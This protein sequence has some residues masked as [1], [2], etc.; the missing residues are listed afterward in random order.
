MSEADGAKDASSTPNATHND[1]TKESRSN[2]IIYDDPPEE[3]II[4]DEADSSRPRQKN[5]TNKSSNNGRKDAPGNSQER[6]KSPA[7]VAPIPKIGKIPPVEKPSPHDPTISSAGRPF[8]PKDVMTKLVGK[9]IDEY[10][11]VVDTDED[12][13]VLGRVEGDLPSMVGRTV[14]NERGDVHDEDGELL[15]YVAEVE[16]YKAGAGKDASETESMD[17]FMGRQKGAFRVDGDGNILDD[18]GNIV[19]SFHD[20]LRMP[21]KEKKDEPGKNS[22]SGDGQNKPSGS[23]PSGQQR[24]NAQ[25]HRKEDSPSDIFLDVKSTTEGIQLTIRIPTV[26]AGGTQPRVSFS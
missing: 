7:Y 10:G 22:S 13:T 11:D 16:G 2:S 17:E 14:V 23:S 21:P 4:D 18:S 15:G 6:E 19:G 5:N 12:G 24:E 20:N 3:E 8:I 1:Q 9:K 26:F 25:S